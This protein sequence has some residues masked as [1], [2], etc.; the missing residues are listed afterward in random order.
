MTLRIYFC[1]WIHCFSDDS[2]IFISV[3]I[4]ENRYLSAYIYVCT[5]LHSH[6]LMKE[7]WNKENEAILSKNN[8]SNKHKMTKAY[9]ELL[10]HISQIWY[11]STHKKGLF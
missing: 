9:F 7:I 5:H 6:I 3:I 2:F 10:W 11:L 1:I 4:D 8:T